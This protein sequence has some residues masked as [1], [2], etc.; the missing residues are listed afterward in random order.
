LPIEAVSE[1]KF[2]ETM[3]INFKGAFFTLQKFLPLLKNGSSVI[4]I[5]AISATQGT[6]N[7]VCI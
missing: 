7:R 3:N 1:D 5:L 4:F 6:P 2:A